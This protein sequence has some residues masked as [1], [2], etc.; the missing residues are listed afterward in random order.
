[1]ERDLTVEKL[2][3]LD[4]EAAELW[5]GVYSTVNPELAVSANEMLRMA[6]ASRWEEY[7]VARSA[8]RPVGVGEVIQLFRDQDSE[9]AYCWLGVLE[10]ER[11]QGAGSALLEAARSAARGHGYVGLRTKVS[12]ARPESV[13]FL[14]RRGF[15]EVGRHQDVVL[16][17]AT[18]NPPPPSAPAG[19]RLTSLAAE[20]DLA[21][22]AY[23]VAC[24]S[25]P[26]IPGDEPLETYSFEAFERRL[27][28][29]STPHDAYMLAVADGQVVGYAFL[30][31]SESQPGVAFHGMTGV[32]RAWRRQGIA[33]ALKSAQIAWARQAGLEALRA[34]NE[35]RNVR[36][37]DLNDELGYRPLPARIDLLGPA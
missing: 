32:R 24:E 27:R 31:L 7:H 34:Q 35:L 3:P 30:D 14:A 16:E 18:A 5:S 19:V 12:E 22:G 26:D 37:R 10:P 13:R 11:R 15:R 20:P 1:M 17:L 8:G 25:L 9:N 28:Q 36:I 21:R 29:D 2:D 6:D 33:R 4:L 23:E